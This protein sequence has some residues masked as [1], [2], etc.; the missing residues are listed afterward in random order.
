MWLEANVLN[1]A[2]APP[3][4]DREFEFG[5]LLFAVSGAFFIVQINR[6]DGDPITGPEKTTRVHAGD[7]VVVV[8]RSGQ[9][10][11]ALFEAPRE[12]VRAGRLTF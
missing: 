6:R 5:E 9:A 1:D 4:A 3:W 8:G 12:K 11:N 7:S 10:I 2:W